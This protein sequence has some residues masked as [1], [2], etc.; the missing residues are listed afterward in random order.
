MWKVKGLVDNLIVEGQGFYNLTHRNTFYGF[1][2]VILTQYRKPEK[3]IFKRAVKDFARWWNSQFLRINCLDETNWGLDQGNSLGEIN[4]IQVCKD[5]SVR[6]INCPQPLR[7]PEIF[8]SLQWQASLCWEWKRIPMKS[9]SR[10]LQCH[11]R[12]Q[13]GSRHAIR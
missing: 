3:L 6:P 2:A 8:Y 11:K 10:F 5:W 9:P 4:E 13:G 1:A 12:A 7:R